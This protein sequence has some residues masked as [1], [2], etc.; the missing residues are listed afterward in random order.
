[1]TYGDGQASYCLDIG[2]FDEVRGN[3]RQRPVW[4]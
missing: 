3:I 2:R 4:Q 1:M